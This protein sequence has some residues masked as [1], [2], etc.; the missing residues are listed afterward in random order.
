MS[1]VWGSKLNF[2]RMQGSSRE[3]L[4]LFARDGGIEKTN[5]KPLNPKP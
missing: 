3:G 1:L 5:P 4:R 2:Y